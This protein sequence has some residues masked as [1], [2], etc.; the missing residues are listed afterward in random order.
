MEKIKL[1]KPIE[2]LDGS[3]IDEL[4]LN[5]E[6]LSVSDFRQISMLEGQIT[7]A[8]SMNILDAV[9]EK[10]LKFEFQLASGFLAATK[11]TKGLQIGDF[12]RVSMQDSL[13]LAKQAAF[14]WLRVE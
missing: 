9:N 11:G 1:V 2:C 7:D 3:K 8:N 5:F 4:S 10:T 6:A 12:S 14:F 13:N